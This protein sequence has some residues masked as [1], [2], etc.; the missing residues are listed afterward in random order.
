MEYLRTTGSQ[1]NQNTQNPKRASDY[2][3]SH[4]FSIKLRMHLKLFSITT[5]PLLQ[6]SCSSTLV[7]NRAGMLKNRTNTAANSANS[8]CCG[9]EYS[10]IKVEFLAVCTRQIEFL[11]DQS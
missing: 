4:G 9:W 6:L 7:P 3:V 10:Q 8:E 2:N 5:P 11:W 1:N